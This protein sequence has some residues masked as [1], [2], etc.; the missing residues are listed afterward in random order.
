MD[1]ATPK[2][3]ADPDTFIAKRRSSSCKFESLLQFLND[4]ENG[5]PTN[6]DGSQSD[7][8]T[9]CPRLGLADISNTSQASHE[10]T[11]EKFISAETKKLQNQPCSS[12]DKVT[13]KEE[14]AIRRNKRY[15]WDE[16]WN[17]QGKNEDQG[18]NKIYDHDSS[19]TAGDENKA[20]KLSAAR[21]QLLSLKAASEEIQMHAVKLKEDQK[22]LKDEVEHLHSIRIE[23]E[24]NHVKTMKQLKKDF[25][26]RKAQIEADHQQVSRL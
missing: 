2:S 23:R 26:D 10:Q 3:Q 6:D 5:L 1:L 21:Q 14:S 19:Q 8:N 4:V 15:I 22:K 9:T 24:A 18:G 11:S 12:D 25:K 13:L 16:D 7:K 17:F 20:E